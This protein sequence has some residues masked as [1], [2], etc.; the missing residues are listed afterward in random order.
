[1]T[2]EQRIVDELISDCKQIVEYHLTNWVPLPVNGKQIIRRT[3]YPRLDRLT[4]S[5]FGSR[6]PIYISEIY[7][8]S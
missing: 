3:I 5:G 2:N 6:V 4:F 7:R 8:V 1:M